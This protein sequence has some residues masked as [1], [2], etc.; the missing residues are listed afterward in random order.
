MLQ[1]VAGYEEVPING[2]HN[3]PVTK[4]A[5]SDFQKKNKLKETGYLEVDSNLALTQLALEWILQIEIQIPLGSRGNIADFIKDFQKN[6]GLTADGKVGPVTQTKMIDALIAENARRN[7]KWYQSVLQIVAGYAEISLNGKK[8]DPLTINAIKQFQ[9]SKELNV[10]G[11]IDDKTQERLAILGTKYLNQTKPLLGRG[12]NIGLINPIILFQ[13]LFSL[14]PSGLLDCKTLKSMLDLLNFLAKEEKEKIDPEIAVKIFSKEKQQEI[15]TLLTDKQRIEAIKWNRENHPS[16]FDINPLIIRKA[17]SKYIDFEKLTQLLIVNKVDLKQNEPPFDDIFVEA[18]HQFQQKC[19]QKNCFII[20]NSSKK[21]PTWLITRG[22][23]NENTLDSLGLIFRKKPDMFKG[24]MPKKLEKIGVTTTN[25][26]LI[27]AENWYSFILKPTF[28]GQAFSEG[29]HYSL[30][31]QLRKAE[32]HLLNG[33]TPAELGIALGIDEAFNG[34]KG[35]RRTKEGSSLHRYGIAIDI[36][37]FKNPWITFPVKPSINGELEQ[38]KGETKEEFEERKK[39][40]EYIDLYKKNTEENKY[41][42]EKYLKSKEFFLAVIKRA[43]QAFNP[44]LLNEISELNKSKSITEFLHKLPI[45]R[46]TRQVWDILTD[47]NQAFIEY[48]NSNLPE[49]QKDYIDF[50]DNYTNTFSNGRSSKRGFISLNQDLVATLRDSC[51]LSWG[52]IDF[53]PN[54]SGDVMHFDMRTI[55]DF[56]SLFPNPQNHPCIKK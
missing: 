52:A 54:E 45:N 31:R 55:P 4:S 8:D 36:N 9:R 1:I 40:K 6:Y 29:I 56:Q 44:S 33:R 39:T 28:L 20:E 48:L 7:V 46:N 41:L 21:N 43:V 32:N 47:L 25:N 42:E 14:G 37:Y 17:L 51:C 13:N 27:N 38:R 11:K 16:T 49:A 22:S 3:D 35:L 5:L 18:V 23:A 30:V 10:T 50:R 53:G 24:S 34:G 15:D 12:I 2:D 19:F 26:T